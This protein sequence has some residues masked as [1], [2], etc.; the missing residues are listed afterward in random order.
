ML[1]SVIGLLS[2]VVCLVQLDAIQL[3]GVRGHFILQGL[4]QP[5]EVSKIH[6]A[7]LLH[8]IVVVQVLESRRKIVLLPEFSRRFLIL[9]R[10]ATS[11]ND[12]RDQA[13]FFKIT[14]S[15]PLL[16]LLESHYD[17]L[18]ILRLVLF[19]FVQ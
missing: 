14:L 19:M 15:Q 11:L 1:T 5:V 2:V 17:R 16:Q 8:L 3:S 10:V 4:E 7:T 6:T 13:I 9:H 12:L 18:I